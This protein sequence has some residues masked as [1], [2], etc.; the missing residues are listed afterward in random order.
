[1]AN[2]T[3]QAWVKP[4]VGGSQDSW[5][6]T[7]NSALDAIDTLVGGVSA[8]EIAKLDGLTATQA[9]LNVLTG[10]SSSLTATNLNH[11]AGL[12]S[13]I[14]SLLDLKAP[15]A[16]PTLASPTLTGTTTAAGITATTV[17]ATTIDLGNWTI[18]QSGTDLKFAYD[19][20]DRLKLTSAGALTV[21]D[22]ITAF[23]GA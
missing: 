4:T 10:V 11:I 19:G 18:T 14:T 3:N 9:N 7:I 2:T 21:E 8:A 13:S 20:T 5:G 12:S 22:D 6:A 23:G 17:E 15:L 1:M 16:S